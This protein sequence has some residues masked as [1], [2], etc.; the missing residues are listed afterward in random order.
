MPLN[1]KNEKLTPPLVT[2]YVIKGGVSIRYVISCLH[3][4]VFDAGLSLSKMNDYLALA[5][6]K[7][8][9]Q[10]RGDVNV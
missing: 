7:I 4:T 10:A 6:I 3:G 2:E 8:V 9:C 5:G 1:I